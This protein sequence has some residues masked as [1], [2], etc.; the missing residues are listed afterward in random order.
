M[1][2]NPDPA[3]NTV[4]ADVTKDVPVVVKDIETGNV[5]G[6][7][8]LGTTQGSSIIAQIPAAVSEVKAGYKTTEFWGV[9]AAALNSAFAHEGHVPKIVVGAVAVFYAAIRALVKINVNKL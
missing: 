8:T 3:V 9:V 7:V 2:V 5:A 1:A 4:I 6:L